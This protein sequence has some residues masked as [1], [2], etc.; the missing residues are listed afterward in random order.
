MRSM[1]N[2]PLPSWIGHLFFLVYVLRYLLLPVVWQYP[3]G[4]SVF[5]VLWCIPFGNTAMILYTKSPAVLSKF[6]GVPFLGSI[7]MELSLRKGLSRKSKIVSAVGVVANAV[8][9]IIIAPW[10]QLRVVWI[11]Y[12]FYS[13]WKITIQKHEEER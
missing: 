13:L 9:A 2:R 5:S 4:R 7:F 8:V 6:R 3:W 1:R 11:I 12:A 10:W